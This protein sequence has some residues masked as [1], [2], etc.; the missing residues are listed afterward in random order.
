MSAILSRSKEL[1]K[2]C[3]AYHVPA[4]HFSDCLSSVGSFYVR[5]ADSQG[6][7]IALETCDLLILL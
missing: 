6:H 3:A 4:W 7:S 1:T 2:E 5:V